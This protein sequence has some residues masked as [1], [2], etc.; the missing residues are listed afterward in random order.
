MGMAMAMEQPQQTDPSRSRTRIVKAVFV[1]VAVLALAAVMFAQ[2][3]S[4]AWAKKNPLV[5]ASL[6]P[7]NGLAWQQKADLT[8]KTT[9]VSAETIQDGARAAAPDAMRAFQLEPLS[10][11][12][13]AL[14]ALAQQQ[15][16]KRDGILLTAANINQRDLFLQ[17]NLLR[18]YTEREDFSQI[19]RQLDEIIR[20]RPAMKKSILPVLVNTLEDDR[21][22]PALA[23]IMNSGAAWTNDFLRLASGNRP[24]L[25]N[26]LAVRERLKPAAGV[27]P[28]TDRAILAALVAERRFAEAYASYAVLAGPRAVKQPSQLPATLDWRSEFYPFD[29]RLADARGLRAF[30]DEAGDNLDFTIGRGEGGVLAER[31]F[32]A[33][34]AGFGITLDYSIERTGRGDN[35]RVEMICEN[36]SRR[37]LDVLPEVGRQTFAV[38]PLPANCGFIK[39][40]LHGRAWSREGTISGS[41]KPISLDPQ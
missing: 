19:T 31:I 27:N 18:L 14:I 21:A 20:I 24:L 38:G 4:G 36:I 6:F 2:A 17:G 10:P 5:A 22:V 3:A 34:T 11:T 26:L 23:Q 33:P 32:K 12:A 30:S 28:V 39:L 29:W 9:A 25:G 15:S 35:I 8:F 41:I 1:V 40:R 13:L 37:I 7:A 16:D